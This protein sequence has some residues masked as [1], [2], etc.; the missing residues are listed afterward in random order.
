MV[1]SIVG[2]LSM[3]HHH[4]WARRDMGE[5]GH[6]G[7]DGLG[8]RDHG[9]VIDPH[10]QTPGNVFHPPSLKYLKNQT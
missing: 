8:G 7:D 3:H 4:G 10:P 2:N 1:C 5:V 9:K 6:L